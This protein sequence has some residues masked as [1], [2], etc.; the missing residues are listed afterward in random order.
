MWNCIIIV[1]HRE[2]EMRSNII[3]CSIKREGACT[4]RVLSPIVDPFRRMESRDITGRDWRRNVFHIFDE[5]PML[6]REYGKEYLKLFFMFFLKIYFNMFFLCTNRFG[7]T[8]SVSMF[9]AAMMYSCPSLE[10]SIYSTC[11]VCLCVSY[12]S[13]L[14]NLIN[15]KKY[16]KPANISKTTQEYPEI[17]GS[18]LFRTGYTQDEGDS[19]EY[20]GGGDSRRDG[21]TGHPHG[22]LVS[23]QGMI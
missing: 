4:I 23:Q 11:K 20:G 12:S 22:E 14:I 2:I 7:K 13:N 5:I 16:F 3:S 10:M 21:R 1:W 6:H 8:I 9:A 15:N 17:P 19:L 18:N